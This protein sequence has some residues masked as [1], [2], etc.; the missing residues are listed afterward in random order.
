MKEQEILFMNMFDINNKKIF[1]HKENFLIVGASL[2]V[3][4]HVLI[5]FCKDIYDYLFFVLF[6]FVFFFLF[7]FYLSFEKFLI[8]PNQLSWLGL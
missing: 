8:L 7:L 3:V 5:F 1:T 6:C 4:F 2:Y